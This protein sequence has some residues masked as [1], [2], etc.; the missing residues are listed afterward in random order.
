MSRHLLRIVS[1]AGLAV[2]LHGAP[3][4]ADDRPVVFVHGFLGN[5]GTWQ[6]AAGRLQGLLLIDPHRPETSWTNHFDAQADQLQSQ[7]STLPS[8]TIAVGHSFGGLV[9]RQWNR[10]HPLAGIVTVGTPHLGAPLAYYGNLGAWLS[11]NFS[12]ADLFNAVSDALSDSEEWQWVSS[13]VLPY[14]DWAF[15]SFADPVFSGIAGTLGFQVGLPVLGDSY[16]YAPYML[17]LN[18]AT[19][20]SREA[21]AIPS[22]V[23]IVSWDPN[24]YYAGPAHALSPDNA[25]TIAGLLYGGAAA[26]EYWADYVFFSDPGNP[27]SVHLANTLYGVVDWILDVDPIWCKAISST[28]FNS[29][30]VSDGVIPQYSQVYQGGNFQINWPGGPAHLQEAKQSDY[31][32]YLALTNLMNVPPRPGSVPPSG[33]VVSWCDPTHLRF[34]DYNGDGKLDLSCH[35]D[36]GQH[37]V[38]FSNGD[39]TFLSSPSWTDAWCDPTHLRSGDYNGDG[40]LDLSCH[41]DA[42]QHVIAFS[43][44]DGTFTSTSWTAPWCDPTH[45]KFGDYN[46]DGKLDLS[47][48]DDYGH[49]IINFSNG[50]GTFSSPGWWNLN[51]PWCDPTHL[52]FGDYNGDHKLDLSCHDDDGHHII[53][54][55]NGDGTFTSPGWWN[56]NA[57]W[58]DPTHLKFGDYNGDGKTDLSCH[59]PDGYHIIAFSN[60]DGTFTSPGWWNWGA[61]W[62]D[63]SHLKFGD[64]NGDGK[65]D[66]SCHDD[67]GHHIIAFSNGNGTFTSPGWWNLNA[68]W[69]D[70]THL[71][72]GDYN[73]DGK[74]DMSCHHPYGI[75]AVAFSNGDGTFSPKNWWPW[76][77]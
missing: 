64:Y 54:F 76:P 25:N 77:Y 67:S 24:N 39:G 48:H 8:T 14:L 57:P 43:N 26:L 10:T 47:C 60:G 69:C 1:L 58:C 52:K 50:D 4:S 46:G 44:G 11:F 35:N 42:G 9:A 56:L 7:L 59:H 21:A 36:A 22:R 15:Y 28:S 66:L 62:C 73:G 71:Q 38:A 63:P 19:N 16:P 29:C 33:V 6:D 13:Y 68:P 75:H 12:A 51:A 32:I 18:S 61:P 40:K 74:L 31:A 23:G 37:L 17:D 5:A 2:L 72:F 70:P 27:D 45:L 55:S 41:N 3:A 34:G 49:H 30:W 53:A 20:L 65:L